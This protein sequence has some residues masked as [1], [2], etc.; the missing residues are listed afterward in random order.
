MAFVREGAS[1]RVREWRTDAIERGMKGVVW[2]AWNYVI[3]SISVEA[4][5][6]D[7]RANVK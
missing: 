7:R 5:F 6:Y 3:Q 2:C 1:E 4:I